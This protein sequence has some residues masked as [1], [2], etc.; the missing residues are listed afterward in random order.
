MCLKQFCAIT[1]VTLCL[2]LPVS[3]SAASSA[4]T[5]TMTA[6]EMSALD[7]RLSLLL[8]QTKSTRQALAESQAALTESR[9]E[10]SKLKSESIKLQIELK[11]QSSLL[12]S[13]N[14]S[15]KASAKEEARTRRRIKAQRNAA[16]VVAVGLLAY[17][18][19]K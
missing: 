16:I 19:D 13:V 4:T 18:V 1:A 15:L 10:L 14:R 5:Y 6:A 7:N 8:Q 9:V 3:A 12:E 2:L 11:A 17:A